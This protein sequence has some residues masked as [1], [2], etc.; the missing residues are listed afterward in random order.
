MR[1]ISGKAKGKLLVAPEGMDTRP[2]TA[3]M[4]EALF[5]MWQFRLMDSSFL[6]LFAGSGS[7]GIEA[8]SRGASNVVFVEKSKKAIDVIK[9]NL[10]N[11]NFTE[12]YQV[13]QDDVFKRVELLKE[14][15]QKF[16]IIYMDPPYTVDEIFVPVLECVALSEILDSD[17]ILA[18]RSRKEKELPE[19]VGKLV[20]YKL[21]TY[22]IS[23]I[24]FYK[25]QEG[26]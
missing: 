23:T 6:D 22:G 20:K 13:C 9:K 2:I 1:V 15:G 3:M 7:M 11:C 25:Y 18:I 8:L 16:D 12:N 4:K 10:K 19:T 24:H 17:G 21:K 26:E 5:S 14:D